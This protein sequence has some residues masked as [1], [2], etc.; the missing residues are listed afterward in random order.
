M[1][2]AVGMELSDARLG[3][4]IACCDFLTIL[5]KQF[6]MGTVEQKAFELGEVAYATDWHRV[7]RAVET[8][9]PISEPM[10]VFIDH[11]QGQPG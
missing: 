4:V 5:P 11:L 2:P 9:S 6:Y 10:G 8:G 1:L 3:R 7:L